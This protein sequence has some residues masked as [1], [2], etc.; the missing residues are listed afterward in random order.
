VWA[1][2]SDEAILL[3]SEDEGLLIGYLLRT[4]QFC[5]M[6]ETGRGVTLIPKSRIQNSEH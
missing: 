1:A 3:K 2:A 5:S 4:R 6:M